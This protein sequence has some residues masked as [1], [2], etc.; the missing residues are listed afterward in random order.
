MTERQ[1][2]ELELAKVFLTDNERDWLVDIEVSSVRHGAETTL[3]ETLR[4]LAL[5]RLD[6]SRL[7]ACLDGSEFV[8]QRIVEYGWDN[9]ALIAEWIRK[10]MPDGD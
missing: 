1:Q 9:G 2:A 4:R 5:A 10:G 8:A 7:R 6:L 3:L